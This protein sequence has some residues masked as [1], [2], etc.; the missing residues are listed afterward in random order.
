MSIFIRVYSL[1]SLIRLIDCPEE[2]DP[3]TCCFCMKTNLIVF[4]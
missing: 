4:N 2:T 3:D 1:F